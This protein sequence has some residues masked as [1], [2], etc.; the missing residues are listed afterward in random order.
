VSVEQ[1]NL[2]TSV[3]DVGILAKHVPS[4]FQLRPGVLQVLNGGVSK[5][6]F[7]PAGFAQVN[8]DSALIVN[9]LEA[10]PLEQL[11]LDE[12]QK[13]LA[14]TEKKLTGNLTDKEK[15]EMEIFLNTFQALAAAVK[16]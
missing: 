12:I 13:G 14:E 16:K 3:G 4:L 11:S 6:F 15:E 9:A 5:E 10:V 1:V 8:P 7:V 2:S